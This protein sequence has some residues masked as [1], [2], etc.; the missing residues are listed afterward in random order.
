MLNAHCQSLCKYLSSSLGA[1]S[2]FFSISSEELHKL[3]TEFWLAESTLHPLYFEVRL[4]GYKPLAPIFFP[5]EYTVVGKSG[6]TVER[7]QR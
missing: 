3:F 2:S 4:D 6:F 7:I 1:L 5:P